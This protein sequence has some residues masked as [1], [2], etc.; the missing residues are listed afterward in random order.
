MKDKK[1]SDV[2]LEN[3]KLKNYKDREEERRKKKKLN[4]DAKKYA[5]KEW[6]EQ[7]KNDRKNILYFIKWILLDILS[8]GINHRWGNIFFCRKNMLTLLVILVWISF[9]DSHRFMAKI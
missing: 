5:D 1:L 7:I 8:Y 3:Q 4:E 6:E 2:L 9:I